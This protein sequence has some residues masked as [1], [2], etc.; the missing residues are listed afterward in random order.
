[1]PVWPGLAPGET[2]HDIGI[3]Q[4]RRDGEVPPV[5]RVVKIR[6]PT[7]D[8][9][10]AENPNGSAVVVLPGGGFMKVVPDK[11]GSEAAPLVKR[12]WCFCFCRSIPNERSDPRRRTSLE[13]TVAGWPASDPDS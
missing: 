3:A 4:P 10:L 9:F 8:V 12:S 7:I 2:S 13:A 11:E 6:K 5:T 1:M